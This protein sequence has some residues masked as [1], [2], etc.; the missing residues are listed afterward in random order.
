MLALRL[1]PPRS[2]FV[3]GGETLRALCLALETDRLD[4]VGQL[5]PGVPVSLMVGGRWNG[6][7]VASKSGAF[8]DD[9]LLRRMLA[10]GAQS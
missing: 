3:A 5:M 6:V 2:L 7:R 4:I 9:M 1:Q 10:L 8:G